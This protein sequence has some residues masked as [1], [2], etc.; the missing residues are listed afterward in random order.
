M[1]RRRTEW[2]MDQRADSDV[3]VGPKHLDHPRRSFRAVPASLI[4]EM[5][6]TGVTLNMIYATKTDRKAIL[7]HRD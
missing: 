5:L 2:W 1:R 7:W 6:Y 4:E 3:A